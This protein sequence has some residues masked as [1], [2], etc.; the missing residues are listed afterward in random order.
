M[1]V[2]AAQIVSLPFAL[3][4]TQHILYSLSH[5]PHFNRLFFSVHIRKN[6]SPVEEMSGLIEKFERKPV[7]KPIYRTGFQYCRGWVNGTDL[8]L[9]YCLTFEVVGF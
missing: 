5:I 7:V 9:A 6:Y 8:V 4:H 1:D 3:F 2:W